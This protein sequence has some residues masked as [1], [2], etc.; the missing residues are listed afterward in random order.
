[1]RRSEIFEEFVKV[2]QEKKIISNNSDKSKKTLENNPRADSLSVSA[3][4][5]LYGVK[6]E[7]PQDMQYEN[8]IM[9]IAH[10]NSLVIAPAYDRLNG[11]VENEI[12]RQ[13]INLRIVNKNP[14]GL[15]TMRRYA[16]QQLLLSLVRVAND[17]D[18]LNQNKLMALADS[19]LEEMTQQDGLTKYAAPSG[20]GKAL[21]VA[22]IV[23]TL[24]TLLY[25]S[26]YADKVKEGYVTDHNAMIA[27]LDD[28]INNQVSFFGTGFELTESAKN[29]LNDF[30]DKLNRLFSVYTKHQPTIFNADRI[31]PIKNK[32]RKLESTKSRKRI[33]TRNVDKLSQQKIKIE[34]AYAE[35]NEAIQETIPAVKEMQKKFSD[36]SWQSRQIKDTGMWK[37]LKD[38][39]LR[40]A[41][42]IVPDQF[43]DVTKITTAYLSSLDD[44][45]KILKEAQDKKV[46]EM[47]RYESAPE[48]V[49]TRTMPDADFAKPTK[50]TSRRQIN[51][52]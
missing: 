3:I 30:K 6:S 14:D 16:H 40:D 48:P 44:I 36:P 15:L 42:A 11:L 34:E 26:L 41:K 28:I 17:L 9:E 47:S 37:S 29:D 1:M 46:Q 24:G 52:T 18:N 38:K 50:G 35:L 45:L 23:G 13:N 19:C 39:V 33:S 10:P 49:E 7:S 2:A 8:N 20:K 31:E 43:D 25:T 5:A 22:G 32:M 51:L 21:L 4:A 12:E 27:E